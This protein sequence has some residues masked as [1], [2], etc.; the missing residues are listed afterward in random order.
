[1]QERARKEAIDILGDDSQDKLP[2][3][4]DTKKM[5][6]INAV[7]KETMRLHNPVL[8]TT[9]REGKCQW[10][11]ITGTF[12]QISSLSCSIAATEDC[13]LNDIFIKKGSL[14]CADILDVHRNPKV[15]NSPYDFKPDRFLPGG[16]AEQHSNSGLA[17]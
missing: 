1:M 11:I 12:T 2:T 10:F 16:E 17:W 5:T 3:I 8:N 7:M 6:Y 13:Y 14:V 9:S 4:E 15:W